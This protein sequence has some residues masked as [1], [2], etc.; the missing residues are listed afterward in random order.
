MDGRHFIRSTFYANAPPGQ[1]AKKTGRETRH[2]TI[3]SN[4]NNSDM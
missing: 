2:N 4:N 3:N 1:Q